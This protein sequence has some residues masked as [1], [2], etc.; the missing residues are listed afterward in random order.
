MKNRLLWKLFL[1]V[2]VSTVVLFWLI[3]LV[4]QHTEESMSYIDQSYRE[5]LKNYAKEA[6]RILNTEGEEALAEWVDHLE[7]K[8]NTWI[9]IATPT[10]STLA[11]TKLSQHYL[12]AFTLGRSIEWKIH[13]YFTQ[14]PTM[15]IPFAD[16][17]TRFL[18][19]LPQRMRPGNNLLI[20]DLI[21]QIAIPFLLLCLI[22]SVLYKH[23]MKPLKKLERA[24]HQFSEG[25]FDVRANEGFSHRHDELTNLASTF[26]HMAD[27]IS[28]LIINQRQLLADLSHELRTPLARLNIAVD[29][30]EQDLDSKKAL[31]RLRYESS[32]MQGL[33][34]D[35]LTL[36]WFN[37]ESPSLA[38]EE[39]EITSLLQV[40]VDDAR[41][42]FSQHNIQLIQPDHDV[43]IDS[44]HQALTA[45]LENIIRNG[46]FHT[47]TG[48][49]LTI[50]LDQK[51]D[52]LNIEIKDQG[53]GVPNEHLEDIFTPFFRL[54]QNLQ[55]NQNDDPSISSNKSGYGL[56]LALAK[57]QILALGGSIHAENINQAPENGLRV[58]IRLPYKD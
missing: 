9:A 6:E 28:T 20:V 48:K 3:D 23:V 44:A 32:N 7:K 4:A 18:I 45:A 13:L 12:D 52:H 50:E 40:I 33:I 21:L 22:T 26:D 38:L 58:L 8:E 11:N 19:Q 34:E 57:R 51:S 17:H 41:Y 35:A 14:N 46:L 53:H 49:T 15:D 16:G 30:V 36:A 27:R 47:P 37:T 5:E 31:E 54:K 2:A 24:T 10:I 1:V 39:L 42:E 43:F 29:C 55:N 25:K 56:G